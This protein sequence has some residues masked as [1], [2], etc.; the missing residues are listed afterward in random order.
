MKEK[1]GMT[2]P[3][4][5]AATDPNHIYVKS[6]VSAKRN[7]C[8]KVMG[9]GYFSLLSLSM[10]S[11]SGEADKGGSFSFSR[12]GSRDCWSVMTSVKYS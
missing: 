10:I 7:I 3:A 6:V 2:A 1:K 11:L 4:A 9:L 12:S 8:V 5:R